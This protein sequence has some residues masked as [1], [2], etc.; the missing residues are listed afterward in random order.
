M[1]SGAASSTISL[2]FLQPRFF[3]S[4]MAASALPPVASMGST[5][6]MSRSA[7]SLGIL[8]K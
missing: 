6:M 3:I 5:I 4:A 7:M 2:M 1:P 8:Q